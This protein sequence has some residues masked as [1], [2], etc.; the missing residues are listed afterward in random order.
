MPQ[1]ITVPMAQEIIVE[2][3]YILRFTALAQATGATVA[4]V[5]VSTIGILGTDL[6]QADG[7]SDFA[8]NP[9]LVPSDDTSTG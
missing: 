2:G 7:T 8:P 1:P 5:N 9:L 3:N 6:V 4:G